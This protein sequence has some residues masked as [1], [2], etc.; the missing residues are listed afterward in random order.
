MMKYLRTG[1][2]LI[3]S[4]VILAVIGINWFNNN[5]NPRHISQ[6]CLHRVETDVNPVVLQEWAE[7]LLRTYPP[8]STN[9]SGPFQIPKDLSAVWNVRDP[10]V[11]LQKAESGG[12]L[13]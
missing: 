10:S 3:G 13:T 4:L 6:K 5:W 2:L 1:I 9:Y 7:Q 12:S 8:E 11:S